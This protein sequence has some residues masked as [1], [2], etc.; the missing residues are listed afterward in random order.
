M[1]LDQLREAAEA[2]IAMRSP[3]SFTIP[4]PGVTLS[5]EVVLALVEY[6]QANE[7][8]RGSNVL[9]PGHRE[10]TRRYMDARARLFGLLGEA[11]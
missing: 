4:E 8:R 2:V 9:Q 3:G 7:G 10:R 5:A 1:T 11:K 6:V